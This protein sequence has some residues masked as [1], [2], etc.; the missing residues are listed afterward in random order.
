MRLPGLGKV[1][2]IAGR[3][4]P[5]SRL[6]AVIGLETAGGGTGHHK[7]LSGSQRE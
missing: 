1:A 4:Q 2:L 6:K 7:A 3:R 5:G